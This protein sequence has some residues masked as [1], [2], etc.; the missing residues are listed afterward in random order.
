[1][2]KVFGYADDPDLVFESRVMDNLLVLL[3]NDLTIL[4]VYENATGRIYFKK[5]FLR[6]DNLN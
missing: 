4:I 2:V 1:M 5:I 3:K 6:K